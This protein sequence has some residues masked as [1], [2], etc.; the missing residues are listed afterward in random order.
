MR[1]QGHSW[2]LDQ[3]VPLSGCVPPLS[4]TALTLSKAFNQLFIVS[5]VMISFWINYG[6]LL[7]FGG[8]ATYAVPLALQ[9]LPAV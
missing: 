5:G 9:A 3:Y 4:A 6:A 2:R 8:K 1:A 7:H